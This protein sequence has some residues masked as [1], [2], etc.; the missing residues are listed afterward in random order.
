MYHRI[1]TAKRDPWNLCVSPTNFRDQ[2][3]A[4]RDKRTILGM[5]Q[6]VDALKAGDLPDDAIALTFDDGYFD[7]FSQAK[8]LVEE[9]EIPTTVFL[10]TGDLGTEAFWWDYLAEVILAY[11]GELDRRVEINGKT[12]EFNFPS[13]DNDK[14]R[15]PI[16]TILGRTNSIRTAAYYEVWEQLKLL[17]APYRDRELARLANML[18]RPA[19]LDFCRPMTREEATGLSSDIVT[20]GSHAQNHHPLPA[21][22]KDEQRRQVLGGKADC[23]AIAGRE[24]TGFAFPHGERTRQL[25][26]TIEATGFR[27]AVSTQGCAV[28]SHQF[29]VFDLP[30]IQVSNVSGNR[31]LSDIGQY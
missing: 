27:W 17:E 25:I 26:E 6:F 8:P 3:E 12:I 7:N 14:S 18:G 22:S 28:N 24:P 20:I 11:P 9:L 5:D 31:L 1:A 21:M 30:R 4:L 16:K 23:F 29:N 10:S 15:R 2:L 19:Y 13:I